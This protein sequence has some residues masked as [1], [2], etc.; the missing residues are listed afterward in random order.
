MTSQD[1]DRAF[2]TRN[3][4]LPQPFS[5][6][7]K[8]AVEHDSYFDHC[9]EDFAAI[10]DMIPPASLFTEVNAR[11]GRFYGYVHGS[12]PTAGSWFTFPLHFL[13]NRSVPESFFAAG[14]GVGPQGNVEWLSLVIRDGVRALWVRA[15]TSNA[16]GGAYS[17]E[18]AAIVAGAL[19]RWRTGEEIVVAG[20]HA[21]RLRSPLPKP[22]FADQIDEDSDCFRSGY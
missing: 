2:H 7:E 16:F 3:E 14:I 4:S 11:G 1:S 13:C 12:L 21:D 22:L 20:I 9:L 17:D 10:P 5:W 19:A 6:A 18:A 15:A 8:K